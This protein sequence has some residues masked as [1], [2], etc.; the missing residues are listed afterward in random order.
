M[1]NLHSFSLNVRADWSA[2]GGLDLLRVRRNTLGHDDS[3]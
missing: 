2:E 3:D 1:Q